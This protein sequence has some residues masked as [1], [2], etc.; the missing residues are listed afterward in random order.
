MND[1]FPFEL[2]RP[3]EDFCLFLVGRPGRDLLPFRCESLKLV[4]AGVISRTSAARFDA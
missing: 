2:D 4:E 1:H 3:V